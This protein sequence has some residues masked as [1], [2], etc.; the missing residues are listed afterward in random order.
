MTL[1]DIIKQVSV[2]V[3]KANPYYADQ[4][5]TRIY[6]DLRYASQCKSIDNY[7][8][9]KDKTVITGKHPSQ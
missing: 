4:L 6:N 9:T 3:K 2:F 8:I 7:V 5:V 1:E